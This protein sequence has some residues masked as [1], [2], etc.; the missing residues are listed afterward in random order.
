MEKTIKYIFIILLIIIIYVAFINI[1]NKNIY[2]KIEN[3]YSEDNEL[4]E[5]PSVSF[6]FKNFYDN[7][8]N[9]LNIILISAP[10]RTEQDEKMY[11]NYKNKGLSFCGISSYL[12]FPEKIKNPYEDRFHEERNHDYLSMVSAWLYCFREPSEKLKNSGLP[13]MLMTEADLMNPINYQIDTT[14]HKEYDFIYVNLNDNDKCDPGWNWY[15]RNWDLAKICLE[16]MCR[17]Y[18]LKGIIVGRENCEFTNYCS[19]RVKVLP[20]LPHHEFKKTLQ[21]CRFLFLPN[22]SDA[23]PRVLSEALLSDIPVLVNYNIIGGWHNVIPRV[24]GEFFTDETNVGE[25]I[26]KILNS[27][28]YSPR[29]WYFNNRGVN[30]SGVL[31]ASFLKKNYPNINNDEISYV[32]I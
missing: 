16:I 31:L 19:E 24:T 29:E 13:L 28:N 3:F 8:G 22:I 26:N 2:N 18:K 15:N 6:P 30:N 11:E 21:K 14:I 7:N 32:Y 27:Y 23:S 9:K 10:F 1:S 25:G 17:D 20:F 12:D 5:I 4:I